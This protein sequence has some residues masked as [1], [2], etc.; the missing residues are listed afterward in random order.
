MRWAAGSDGS[1]AGSGDDDDDDD[2][3]ISCQVG[4]CNQSDGL[5]NRYKR[6]ERVAGHDIE[7]ASHHKDSIIGGPIGKAYL[8]PIALRL[9]QPPPPSSKAG[10]RQ[11]C[12][13]AQL[14]DQ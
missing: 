5:G 12:L 11:M 14:Q 1:E 10:T 7:E 4:A 9:P 3:E 13:E 6:G 2:I 8:L